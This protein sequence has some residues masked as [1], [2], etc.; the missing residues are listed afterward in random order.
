MDLPPEVCVEIF[1]KLGLEDLKNVLLVSKCWKGAAE[2]KTLWKNVSLKINL[3]KDFSA[4]KLLES[5]RFLALEDLTLKGV[6]DFSEFQNEHLEPI[7]QLKLKH[8]S[9]FQIS[10]LNAN[11]EIFAQVLNRMESVRLSNIADSS[12][13]HMETFINLLA[14]GSSI[15]RH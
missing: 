7:S 9:L 2:V 4:W 15:K 12:K 13:N 8:L 10:L 14:L 1:G 5:L 11:P 6:D 3:T